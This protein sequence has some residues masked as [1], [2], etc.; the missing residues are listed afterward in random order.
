MPDD[1]RGVTEQEGLAAW[2]AWLEKHQEA[3]FT[4]GRLAKPSALRDM[5]WRTLPIS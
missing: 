5:A 1:E 4:G 3:L 2:K